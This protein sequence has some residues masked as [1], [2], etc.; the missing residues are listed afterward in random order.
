MP[1]RQRQNVL[2]AHLFVGNF[3][4]GN[5]KA[6]GDSDATQNA[7]LGLAGPLQVNPSIGRQ[8]ILCQNG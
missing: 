6:T 7:L 5:A 3:Y 4:P 1:A 8:S 2:L